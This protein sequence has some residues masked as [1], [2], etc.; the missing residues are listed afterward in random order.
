MNGKHFTQWPPAE[1]EDKAIYLQ[2]DGK[3]G[4]EQTLSGKQF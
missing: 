2:E 3:L 1:K 4:L